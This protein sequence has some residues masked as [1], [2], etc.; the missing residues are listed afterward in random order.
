MVTILAEVQA[1]R[2]WFDQPGEHSIQLQLL[3][4]DLPTKFRAGMALPLDDAIT[5]WVWQHQRPLIIAAEEDS[6]FP[7]FAHLLLNW[8]IKYFCAVPLMIAHRRIGVLGL[9]G[10]SREALRNLDV[11]FVKRGVANVAKATKDDRAFQHLAETWGSCR[12]KPARLQEDVSSKDNFEGI[13][14]RGASHFL[15]NSYISLSSTC[16][17]RRGAGRGGTPLPDPLPAGA[18]RGN[19]NRFLSAAL[20]KSGMRPVCSTPKFLLAAATKP[21]LNI[22]WPFGQNR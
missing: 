12:S 20:P 19:K 4:D 9:A 16:L 15:N 3:M 1:L 22:P 7:H 21:G 8:G 6:R 13:I 14:A 5:R 17:W 10:A 11:E 2:V 18:G